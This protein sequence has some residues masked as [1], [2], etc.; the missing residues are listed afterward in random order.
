MIYVAVFN[1]MVVLRLA[2]ANAT[3]MRGQLYIPL[4]IAFFLFSAF[5]FEV[6]CDWTGYI[7]QY[8]IYSLPNFYEVWSLPRE[9]LWVSLFIFQAWLELPYPWINVFSSLIFFVGLNAMARRQP[10]PMAFLVLLFPILIINMPMSGIRQGAA[11]GIMFFAFNAFVDH[12]TLRFVILTLI[13]AGLHSSALVFLLL[14]PLVSG[15]YSRKRLLLAVCLALP[16]SMLLLQGDAGEMAT[17]RYV[18]TGIDAAGAVFRVGLITITGA[19]F[20]LFLRRKW[21]AQFPADFKL[22]I[23]GALLMLGMF[24]LLPLSSVVADRLAY[25]LLPIQAMIFA[26]LPFLQIRNDRAI[27]VTFPYV[28]L[29][30]TFLVWSSISWHFAQCYL[31]YQTWLFGFPEEVIWAF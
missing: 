12:K 10:D 6:G 11:I 17:G 3:R 24:A 15:P 27:H 23:I 2:L 4:L 26:R 13:A 1:L 18:G 7:N 29:G 5:R 30:V 8:L 19:Y 16:G 28:L 25:Y 22:A 9:T 14:A 21:Q 31:P 20:F